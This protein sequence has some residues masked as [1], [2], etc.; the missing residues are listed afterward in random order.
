MVAQDD[1]E[2]RGS[3]MTCTGDVYD[4]HSSLLL[5]SNRSKK[6]GGITDEREIPRAGVRHGGLRAE[7]ARELHAEASQL[8]REEYDE[9]AKAH[10]RTPVPG[11]RR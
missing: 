6:C 7:P 4:S 5:W 9:R 2:D 8:L 11:D 3:D 10:V 1:V